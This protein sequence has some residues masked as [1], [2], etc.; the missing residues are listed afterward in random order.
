MNDYL[1]GPDP[2][3]SAR[4]MQAMMGMNRLVVAELTAAYEGK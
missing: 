2:A 1:G 3:G 4:A